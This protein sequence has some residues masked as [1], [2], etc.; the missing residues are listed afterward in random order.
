MLTFWLFCPLRALASWI[1]DAHSFLSTTFCYH[2]L[3]F[4]S[5]RS[6]S[7][8]SSHLNL[9]LALLPFLSGL[10]TNIFLTV[11]P[12]TIH[13]TCPICS[14]LFFLIPATMS[15]S[16]YS[17]LSSWSVLI[18]HIPCSTAG[19][20]I[21][22]NILLSHV[23]RLFITISATAHISLPYTAAGLASFYILYLNFNCCTHGSRP[24]Y[25]S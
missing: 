22:L 2:L 6:F 1:T 24:K 16:L 20:C 15:K 4:F 19:T 10:F 23:P 5:H 17:S 13:A 12:W 21:L 9:G 25:L 18:L 11:L 8:S 7:T 3:I 14:S